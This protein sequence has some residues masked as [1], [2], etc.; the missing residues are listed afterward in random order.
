MQ[1]QQVRVAMN[2]TTRPLYRCLTY[3]ILNCLLVASGGQSNNRYPENL[4]PKY[5]DEEKIMSL[6][7]RYGHNLV[8]LKTRLSKNILSAGMARI[9]LKK[10][11]EIADRIGT[12]C[13]GS[14]HRFSHSP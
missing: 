1:A 2:F 5:F 3:G 11:I 6:F 13:C 7:K 12:P 14:R 4:D 10:T 8:G 9:S